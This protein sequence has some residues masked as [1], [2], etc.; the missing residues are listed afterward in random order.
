MCAKAP[1]QE[2]ASVRRECLR[3]SARAEPGEADRVGRMLRGARGCCCLKDLPC[4]GEANEG[5][6]AGGW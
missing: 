5:F 3:W 4:N 6:S 2:E 1:L